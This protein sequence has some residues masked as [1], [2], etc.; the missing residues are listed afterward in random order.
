[1]QWSDT[2]ADAQKVQL[3]ILRAMSGEQRFMHALEMS[4]FTR[5]LA[6][7]RIRQEHPEWTEAE[8]ERELLRLAFLPGSLPLG[9][10]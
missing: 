6:R 9:L 8:V 1:V 4:L 3:K 7:T 2:T 5:Q 10:P